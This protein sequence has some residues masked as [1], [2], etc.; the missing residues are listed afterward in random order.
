MKLKSSEDAYHIKMIRG[1]VISYTSGIFF[2]PLRTMLIEMK[3]RM[4]HQYSYFV[5]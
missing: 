1:L 2:L 3:Y 5:N 4:S